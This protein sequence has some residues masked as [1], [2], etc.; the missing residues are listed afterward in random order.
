M[1]ILGNTPCELL[2]GLSGEET[3]GVVRK[4]GVL[5]PRGV[6][7]SLYPEHVS[8]AERA[9]LP[10]R[11]KAYFRSPFRS[12]YPTFLPAPLRFP[13]RSRSAHMLWADQ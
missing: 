10:L 12:A 9:V 5:A 4:L 13:P 11:I 1:T 6:E 2:G 8:G 3:G 7:N